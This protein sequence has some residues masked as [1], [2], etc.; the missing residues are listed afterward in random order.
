M[1][2]RFSPS[3]WLTVAVAGLAVVLGGCA[4]SDPDMISRD[5]TQTMSQLLAGVALSVRQVTVDVTPSGGRGSGGGW[6]V[7]TGAHGGQVV[8]R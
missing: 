5:N 7:R 2:Y 1:N 8:H 3:N 4:T 6:A